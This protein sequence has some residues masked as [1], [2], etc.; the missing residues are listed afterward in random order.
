MD[1][2]L[3][4]FV[5]VP[6]GGEK[7]PVE[8][9]GKLE[10]TDHDIFWDSDAHTNKIYDARS[11]VK[12]CEI[13]DVIRAAVDLN[14]EENDLPPDNPDGIVKQKTCLGVSLYPDNGLPTEEDTKVLIEKY[15]RPYHQKVSEIVKSPEITFC[16]DC[17]SMLE[18]GPSISPDRGK[19]RPLFSLGNREGK[20]SSMESINE[21]KKIIAKNFQVDEDEVAINDPFKGGFIT[22]S[23]GNNPKPWIQIEMN[24]VLYLAPKYFDEKTLKVSEERLKELNG[25]FLYSLKEFSKSL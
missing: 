20:T 23:Y 2:K 12:Y 21:L 13:F 7:V 19:K 25:F 5:S 11:L 10:L 8:L 4:L 16:L 17:H 3:P 22:K 14:R 9:Q 18:K 1:E 15:Y 24:R 6:H